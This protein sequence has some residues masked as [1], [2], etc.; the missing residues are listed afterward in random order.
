M[1]R[2]LCVATIAVLAVTGCRSTCSSRRQCSSC[3][4]P[5]P[6][7]GTVPRAG[8]PEI[9]FPSAPPTAAPLPSTIAPPPS[10]LVPLPPAPAPAVA[11][12]PNF[13]AEPRSSGF[14]P[15]PEIGSGIAN[16]PSPEPKVLLEKPEF[17]ETSRTSLKPVS[18]TT[19]PSFREVIPHRLATGLRP[20]LRELDQLKMDGYHTLVC[21]GGETP[22]ENDRRIFASRSMH[23][24]TGNADAVRAAAGSEGAFVYGSD[25]AVLRAW[26]ASYFRDV[27]FLSPD[28]ARIRAERLLK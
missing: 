24:V 13:P 1:K 8:A 10:T 9:I 14:V 5:G 2:M 4:P 11:P 7:I 19:D 21:V 18:R 25:V 16:L 3:P 22:T 15:A 6:I 26:W 23:L 28:A 12:A 17:S 27:D 20:T